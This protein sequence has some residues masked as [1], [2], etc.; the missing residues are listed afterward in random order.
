MHQGNTS[1]WRRPQGYAVMKD[2]DGRVLFEADSATCKHCNAIFHVGPKQRAEDIG[3]L[4]GVCMGIV[5]PNCVGKGCDEV[6]RKLDRAEASY[7]AR[8]SYGII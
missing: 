7:H 6:Q 1:M 2:G 8:R 3:G 4:C 5:C